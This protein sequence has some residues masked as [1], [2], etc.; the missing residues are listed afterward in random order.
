[1]EEER[2]SAHGRLTPVDVEWTGERFVLVLALTMTVALAIIYT[3]ASLKH[4]DF[5]WNPLA[6]D[7]VRHSLEFDFAH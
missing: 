1:M 7:I 5:T 3:I 6:H 2:E 4:G